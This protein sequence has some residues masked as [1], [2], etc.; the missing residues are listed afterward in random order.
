MKKSDIKPKM[1]Y[2]MHVPWG[3]IKQ[4]PHFLAEKLSKYYSVDVGEKRVLLPGAQKKLP[5]MVSQK[6]NIIKYLAIPLYNPLEKRI[7]ILDWINKMLILCKIRINKYKYV[8]VTSISSYYKIK[9]II[10]ERI[11]LIYD[12][13]DDELEFPKKYDIDFVKKIEIELVERANYIFCTSEHLKKVVQ[14][15]TETSKKI[16]INNNAS[17]FPSIYVPHLNERFKDILTTNSMVYIGT[18]AEW[19]DFDLIQKV[20]KENE[21]IELYLI[22]PADACIPTHKKIHILGTCKHEEIW[23]IMK[24]AKILIMPF[25]ITPLIESVNPVKLYEYIWAHKPIIAP[26][27]SESEKFSKY[28]YLYEGYRDIENIIR[29]IKSNKYNPKYTLGEGK[30]FIKIN[31]WESRTK[32]IMNIIGLDDN[33]N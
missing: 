14:L 7:P 28:V 2:I 5:T 9:E 20:L 27:Y 31:D 23:G 22:G 3:W 25:K 13:M 21:D 4:R 29:E 18:I 11:V 12:C 1:L 26:K 16:Y 17:S 10:N 24:A 19:F 32:D 6:V 30:S 8:W 33:K 15:R